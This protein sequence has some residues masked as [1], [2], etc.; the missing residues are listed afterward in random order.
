[1]TGGYSE[2]DRKQRAALARKELLA[3]L[4]AWPEAE[5]RKFVGRHYDNYLLTVDIEDQVRHAEFM[6][7]A[8]AEDQK[9]ATTVKTNQF[10][11]ITEISVLAPDHPRLLS[12]IAA[13]C[14]SA[15]AKIDGAH[16]FTT[17][18]GWALDTILINR[19]LQR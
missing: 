19:E 18:D 5:Q 6:R 8:L 12:I 11:A 1:M 10:Q 13:A 17:R 4:S 16:V 3:Q 2:I 14:S 9:L 7:G 15:G